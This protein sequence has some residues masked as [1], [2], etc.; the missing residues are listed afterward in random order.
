MDKVQG[1][2]DSY[3]CRV[4]SLPSTNFSN[5]RIEE[6]RDYNHQQQPPQ[7]HQP[8]PL[9]HHQQQQQQPRTPLVYHQQQQPQTPLVHH[10]QQPPMRSD[11]RNNN[12]TTQSVPANSGNS[13]SSRYNPPHQ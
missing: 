13:A 5:S 8:I 11:G 10:Q 3:Q 7:Q 9:V 2:P 12:N 1:T 6:P 4:V